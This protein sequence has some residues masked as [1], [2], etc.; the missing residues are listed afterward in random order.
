[1]TSEVGAMSASEDFDRTIEASHRALDQIARGDPGAFFELYSRREDATLA[2]PFGPPARGRAQIEETGRR[3]ASNYR[4]GRA[5]GFENFAKCVTADLA[6]ILEI[7][8]FEAKVGGS[9]E[10]TPVGLRVTSIF[11]REDGTWKLVHRH[12]DP[13]TTR[14]AAESVTQP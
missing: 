3:A 7:E 1:M 5:V 6:Y 10:V 2:N 4:D 13:I 14:R 8:R 9:E 11:R 12:A